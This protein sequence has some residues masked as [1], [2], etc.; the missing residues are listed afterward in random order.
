MRRRGTENCSQQCW[1]RKQFIW[2]FDLSRSK[3][4]RL[5]GLADG[6]TDKTNISRGK[7]SCSFRL[8]WGPWHG[9]SSHG[10]ST[11]QVR[12]CGAGSQDWRRRARRL[13]RSGRTRRRRTRLRERIACVSTTGSWA[14][15]SAPVARRSACAYCRWSSA[16]EWRSRARARSDCRMDV[17]A[18]A[19]NRR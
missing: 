16:E 9:T 11:G 12:G 10:R 15:G 8:S 13:P 2:W 3:S 1:I 14:S 6:E 18:S 17:R 7:L 4:I 5:L 19:E